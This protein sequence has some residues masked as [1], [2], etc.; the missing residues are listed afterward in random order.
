[1]IRASSLLLAALLAAPALAQTA[2][3]PDIQNESNKPAATEAIQKS[4][5][6]AVAG[7]IGLSDNEPSISFED[8][9]AKPD[10]V[11]L[12]YRFARQQV[13]GGD[14]KGAAATL[15]RILLINPDLPRVRL[16]YA[17]VL[18]RLDDLTESQL[19]LQR[20]NELKITDD[21]RKELDVYVKA[22]AKRQKRDHL[23]GQVG[24]G[25]EYDGNR[26][27]FPSSGHYLF[28]GTPITPGTPRTDDTSAL[29]LG[30]VQERHTF[31]GNN[32]A[33][34]TFDYFRA[35]QTQL[36]T[37]NIQAYALTAGDAIRTPWNFT[38]KP[39]AI[40]DHVLLAQSTF[41]RDRGVD[42]RL[43]RKITQSTLLFADFRDVF[44]DYVNSPAFLSAHGFSG[45]QTDFTVGAEKV[46]SPRQK[47]TI[48]GDY[49]VK[50]AFLNVYAYNRAAFDLSHMLLLKKGVF[51]VSS[52]SLHYDYY[53]HPDV[54]ISPLYRHDETGRLSF[55]LGA[56]LSIIHPVLKDVVGTLTY[57]YYQAISSVDNYSYTNNKIAALLTYRW[58]AAF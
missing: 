53:P 31:S 5:L 43:E 3:T 25:W 12:N 8:V 36:K 55:T 4:A 21:V 41:L 19:E 10:D 9:M 39:S 1:M 24:V 57:E 6:E 40:F 26:N 15:Q 58:D 35:E 16:F 44:N 2:G 18:Y 50:H 20:L 14:L 7:K 45:I 17:V 28:A 38:V 37:L 56:P 33:F 46:L 48:S 32:E 27:A 42:L 11:E 51:L 30:S 22:I 54:F 29:F 34:A 52:L 49:G 47:L 13:R 23:S